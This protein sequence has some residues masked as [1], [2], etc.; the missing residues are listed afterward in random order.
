VVRFIKTGLTLLGVLAFGVCMLGIVVT[1][2][3]VLRPPG[4]ELGEVDVSADRLRRTVRKVCEEFAPR[5]FEHPENLDRLAGWIES[6]FAET[7]LEVELQDYDTPHGR[8]RNV[9]ARRQGLD[10]EAG[11][12]IVGAHYDSYEGLPGANDNA[13]GVAVLLELVRHL[14]SNAPRMTH[15]FVAFGSEEPPFFGTEQMGSAAFARSLERR[16]VDVRLMIALDLVGSYSDVPGSQNFPLPG[17]GL[18]YPDA[19]NFVAIVG[20]LGSGAAIRRVKSRMKASGA[21]PVHSFRAPARIPGVNWS[22]NLPFRE[23][24]LPAVLV[25]DTAFMRYPHY[26][27]AEDTPEKLDYERMAQLTHAL[28]AVLWEPPE[29]P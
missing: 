2:P 23:R 22:D 14:D 6:R 28:L 12:L 7:G 25:T 19:G 24:D 10:P 16:G 9:V 18:L 13:S 15:Y 5:G 26:H 8:F 1:G 27:S 20:D 4:V 29:R 17:L 11:A 21:I 3:V